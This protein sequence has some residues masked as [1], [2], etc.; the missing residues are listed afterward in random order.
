MYISMRPGTPA[1]STGGNSEY[2]SIELPVVA[3]WG[4]K[5]SKVAMSELD[6]QV[7]IGGEN[8]KNKGLESG[9]ILAAAQWGLSVA[10]WLLFGCY[11][12]ILAGFPV[13]SLQSLKEELL[14]SM[15]STPFGKAGKLFSVPSFVISLFMPLC[16]Y[17]LI[18]VLK[19]D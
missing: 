15:A 3:A 5:P 2:A 14:R 10:M 4:G 11:M 8:S 13:A 19:A 12:A 9:S 17:N 7:G 16:T 18:C 6:A 1:V